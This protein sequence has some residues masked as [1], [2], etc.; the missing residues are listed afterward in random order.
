MPYFQYDTMPQNYLKEII[1]RVRESIYCKIGELEVTIWKTPEPVPFSEKFTGKRQQIKV[2]QSWG[3]LW[4]CAWFNFTGIVDES[5]AGSEVV[6]LI[7]ISGEACIFNPEGCPVQGLTTVCSEFDYSL[8]RPGKKVVR[9]LKNAAGGEQIELWADAGC[10]DLFGMYQDSGMLK[11]ASIAVFNEKMHQLYY[12][13]EVLYELMEQLP[14]EK[15]RRSSIIFSL[16]EASGCLKKFTSEEVEKAIEILSVELNKKCG[17]E[18]LRISAIGHAH[19]DLAWLWPIRETIR[20]GARTFATALKNMEFYPEYRFGASQPQLYQWIKD[21]YPLLYEKVKEQVKRGKWEVQGAMWVEADTN[22]SGGEALIRQILFGKKFFKEEFGIDVNVLWLPDV[23]GYSAA[24]PQLMK[25]SGVDYF[26]TTK[27]SWSKY[28]R[29]PHHTFWWKGI[30]GSRVLAHMP[31]EGT[32]NSSAAPRAIVAAE[33]NFIDKGVSDRCLMLFGIGDGGGGPGEEHLERLCREKSL[34]GLVPVEQELSSSFFEKMQKDA[35]KY[36]TWNGELYLEMHQGTY[37]TQ[38]KNKWYNRKIEIMLRELELVSVQ[39]MVLSGKDYPQKDIERIWKEVLLYQFH[40]ILPGSSIKKVYD[41]SL[42]RYEK[43]SAEIKALTSEAYSSLIEE[44]GNKTENDAVLAV[45][46]LS[47]DRDEWLQIKGEWHHVYIPALG[48]ILVGTDSISEVK[49]NRDQDENV[50]EN[51]KIKITF[52]SDGSIRSIM[53]KSIYREMIADGRNANILAVYTEFGN[54][55]DFPIQYDETEPDYF[56]MVKCSCEKEGPI[57]VKKTVYRYG[58]SEL[59]QKVILKDGYTRIDFETTVD[60]KESSKMLRTVFPLSVI[61]DEANCDIQFGSIKRPTHRN[62]SWDMAKYEVCAHKWVDLSNEKYGA[63][64]LN[65]CKYG[66]KVK[67]NTIELNLLRSTNNP[68]IHADRGLHEFVYS[69]YPHEG[70]HIRGGVVKQGYELNIP[71]NVIHIQKGALAKGYDKSLLRIDKENII[72]ETVKK[73]EDNNDIILR[74]Y[75]CCGM[76]TTAKISL[77]FDFHAVQLVD[78]I[79]RQIHDSNISLD[80]MEVAFGPYEIKTLRVK[81]IIWT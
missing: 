34:N 43:L 58:D 17:D 32:Y 64:L 16:F 10:N 54:A 23:F 76:E 37:T 60:W 57:S 79:E 53:D 12:D 44:S 48:Y 69:L 7:D 65:D 80:N 9:Y 6:L 78:L 15:A 55:W 1:K 72:L 59:V 25:K 30:D 13:F 71:V 31:P 74:F 26:M 70:N 68:G 35:G 27:L 66:Y 39:A 11:E 75:E 50:L 8:G 2:G 49:H 56:R 21:Y 73:A 38:A 42:E 77:G 52:D 20:K 5:A 67:D 41:E 63:A 45:N 46:T 28:N 19:I 47:W 14:K 4:D 24:L 29:H 62:T 18:S 36:E 61:N 40:D 3:E 51:E 81:N 22:I 33:N